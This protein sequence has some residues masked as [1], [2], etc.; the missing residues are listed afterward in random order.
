MVGVP[1]QPRE[2]AIQT[3]ST[4]TNLLSIPVD[5]E[6]IRADHPDARSFPLTESADG[7]LSS[8]VWEC[9]AGDMEF[10]YGCDEIVHILEGEVIVR[11]LDAE[12][13]LCAGDVAFFSKGMTAEW[14]VPTYVK[15]FWVCCSSTP[16]L[17]TRIKNKLR[18]IGR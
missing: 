5:S 8:G 4:R 17:W 2:A 16:S 11:V 13:K 3:G 6:R 1:V 10:T 14:K 12:Y 15:K 9:Y 18:R 7:N